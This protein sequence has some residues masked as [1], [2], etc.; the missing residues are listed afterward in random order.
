[1]IGDEAW[2]YRGTKS[3]SDI[4]K[5]E[6]YNLNM[7]TLSWTQVQCKHPIAK[8]THSIL[9][10]VFNGTSS[11]LVL[12]G[13]SR[14]RNVTWV[15]DLPSLSWREY[16]TMS[17]IVTNKRRKGISGLNSCVLI[18]GSVDEKQKYQSTLFIRLEPKSLQQLAM[19]TIY[20]HKA[21]LPWKLLPNKLIY[22]L[23]LTDTSPE[24]DVDDT[25]I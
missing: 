3:V 17:D 10:Q 23:G 12:H 14:S 1:M 16:K 5:G 22:N 4:Y 9:I 19:K 25:G 6:L 15:L 20:E 7:K 11:K 18:R 24:E 2:M 8:L 13:V 21:T